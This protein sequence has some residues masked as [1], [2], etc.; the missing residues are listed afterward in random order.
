M[1]GLRELADLR[2]SGFRP[3]AVAVRLVASHDEWPALCPW[4]HLAVELLP[5]DSIAAQDFRPLVGLPVTVEDW[6]EGDPQRLRK[7]AAA[8]AEIETSRLT[9]VVRHADGATIHVREGG[10]TVSLHA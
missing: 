3:V 6:A 2:L 4:G 9:M 8:V 10:Q 5:E 1:K 7:L